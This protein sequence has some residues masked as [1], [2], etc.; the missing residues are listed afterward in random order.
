MSL[1]FYNLLNSPPGEAL[2]KKQEPLKDSNSAQAEFYPQQNLLLA[3]SLCNGNSENLVSSMIA[4]S[5]P[6]LG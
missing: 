6:T 5:L 4:V 2:D 3:G 1:S